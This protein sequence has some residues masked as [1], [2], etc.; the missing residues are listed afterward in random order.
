MFFRMLIN[1]Y[2]Q[3]RH[4]LCVDRISSIDKMQSNTTINIC[5]VK[6]C[7][8][9]VSLNN[10]MFR[11]LCRPSSGCT[12]SYFKSNYVICNVSCSCKWNHVIIH[13]SIA[14]FT[15]KHRTLY[16]RIKLLSHSA[17]PFLCS[18]AICEAYCIKWY[19]C[20]MMVRC[21]LWFPTVMC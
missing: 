9:I 12:A 17:L 1:S 19:V 4:P 18:Y 2:F 21:C 3:V 7:F 20:Y 8:Y 15:I 16:I 14:S 5:I 11:P 6:M 10:D 13:A